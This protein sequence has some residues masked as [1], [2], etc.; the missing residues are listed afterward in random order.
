M[1]NSTPVVKQVYSI[2]VL[3]LLL[4]KIYTETQNKQL[5]GVIG[6]YRH[7]NFTKILLFIRHNVTRC[8]T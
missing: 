1:E 2:L 3:I 6:V 8:C 7:A 4:L 5:S